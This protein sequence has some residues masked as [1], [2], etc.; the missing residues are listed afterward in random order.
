MHTDEVLRHLSSGSVEDQLAVL[1]GFTPEMAVPEI[2]S[3]LL[4][5]LTNSD[6]SVVFFCLDALI[7]QYPARVHQDAALL[8]PLL[9]RLLTAHDGPVT[10]RAM[11]ALSVTGPG[12]VDALLAYIRQS[13]DDYQLQMG[14]WALGRNAHIRRAPT[15]INTL[16]AY[17]RHSNLAVRSVALGVLMDLSPLRP[18]YAYG[19]A[20]EYDFE[21]L[22]PELLKTARALLAASY[23]DQEMSRRYLELLESH[24][25]PGSAQ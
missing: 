1:R 5:N 12:S 11:W 21:L 14:I 2:Y 4:T 17:L 22:Y 16:R 19:E 6:D 8:T 25:G 24:L 18:W 3:V 9:L 20:M 13:T 15:A 10:D 23:Q 7:K